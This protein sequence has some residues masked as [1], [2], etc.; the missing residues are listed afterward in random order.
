MYKRRKI[1][2]SIS[3]LEENWP[4]FWSVTFADITTLLMSAFVLWYALTAMKYPPELLT[5]K[6]I[7]EMTPED[8]E[9]YIE[10]L[11]GKQP[12]PQ[13]ILAKIKKLTPLQKRL[14]SEM[15]TVQ[16]LKREIQRIIEAEGL[17]NL[18]EVEATFEG[19]RITAH[20]PLLFE[21]GKFYLKKNVK[22]YIRKLIKPL[23]IIKEDFAISIE[24]HTDDIQI[25]PYKRFLYR[26]NF[27]LS[28]K[29]AESVA[30]FIIK[31]LRIP[32]HKI[33]VAGY[34]PLKP[35]VP[36][37][38]DKNRQYNRRVEMFI[39]IPPRKVIKKQ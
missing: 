38:N 23:K 6:R 10:T 20:Q 19:V 24:G 13:E 21:E 18:V 11:K 25:N 28:T 15:D 3:I 37:I 39:I 1:S 26:D 4:P 5:I 12:V 17:E 29:R 16:A 34:G 30:D 7:E 27:E 14:L 8:I 22:E 36:N 33:S 9:K 35:L 32:P 31:E 2:E